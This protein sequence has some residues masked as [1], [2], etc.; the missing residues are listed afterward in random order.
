M[1]QTVSGPYFE[2]LAIQSYL[3]RL[4]TAVDDRPSSSPVAVLDYGYWMQRYGDDPAAIGSSIAIND[5]S[6][7]VVGVTPRTFFGL[8]RAVAPA[9]TVTMREP[10]RLANL[11]IVD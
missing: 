9:L 5:T 6:H 3:G 7:T 4:S 10:N 11:W 8:D 2:T 1:V